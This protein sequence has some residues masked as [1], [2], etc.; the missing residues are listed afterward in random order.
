MITGSM[1]IL[2]VLMAAATVVYWL[3]GKPALRPLFTV[4][5]P[6]TWM[7]IIP[8]LLASG[9]LLSP[10]SPLYNWMASY[11]L[12]V[13]LLLLTLGMNARLFAMAP[14]AAIMLLGGTVGIMLGTLL[15]FVLLKSSLPDSGWQ[16]LSMLSATWVGG[17]TNMLAIE[18]SMDAEPALFEPLLVFSTAYSYVWLGLLIILG[19]LQSRLDGWLRAEGNGL[20]QDLV[21]AQQS[22]A[23]QRPATV[24][25]LVVMLGGAFSLCILVRGI[26]ALLPAILDPVIISASTLTILLV[27]II[28]LLLRRTR[29]RHL[30]Q[31]GAANLGYL[32]LLLLVGALGAQ[33]DLGL[34]L[35]SPQ[36][37]V[38]G[39]VI[40]LVQACVLLFLARILHVPSFFIAAGSMANVGGAVSAPVAAAA[41]A[42]TLVPLAALM[43]VMGYLLGM[44]APMGVAAVLAAMAGA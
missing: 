14:T 9:G 13:A 17:A 39:A 34:L 29:A 25:D 20:L 8:M 7:F 27:V 42:P 32:L 37:L 35:E 11:L 1:E 33:A 44:A 36:L 10:V 30:E 2:A 18:Q 22:R 38:A 19:A 3:S 23:A 4:L 41:Y 40:V 21:D 15:A 28:G 26:A 24:R 16:S 6:V 43:G 5:P 12:P 31:A